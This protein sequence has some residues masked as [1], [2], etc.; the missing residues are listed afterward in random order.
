MSWCAVRT[1][2]LVTVAEKGGG[3]IAAIKAKPGKILL[4][5]TPANRDGLPAHLLKLLGRAMP[6]TVIHGPSAHP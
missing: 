4:T 1:L 5:V 2:L 6:G 3:Y